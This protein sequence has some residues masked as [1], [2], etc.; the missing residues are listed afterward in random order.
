MNQWLSKVFAVRINCNL[1]KLQCVGEF[2][3]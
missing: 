3:T 2:I 1:A